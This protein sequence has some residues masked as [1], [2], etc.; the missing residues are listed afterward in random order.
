MFQW[1]KRRKTKAQERKGTITSRNFLRILWG[2]DRTAARK[3]GG[4]QLRE[5]SFIITGR[6]EV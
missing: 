5:L 3:I 4:V 1:R 6:K 2:W